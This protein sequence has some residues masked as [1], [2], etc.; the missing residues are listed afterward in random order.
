[1]IY[2]C[3]LKGRPTRLRGF[4]EQVYDIYRYLPPSTQVKGR[5][6]GG[7]SVLR[8][9]HSCAFQGW[10]SQFRRSHDCKQH[11]WRMYLVCFFSHRQCVVGCF[12]FIIIY[13]LQ[14]NYFRVFSLHKKKCRQ[15][16]AVAWPCAGG[17]GFS[18]HA[19]AWIIRADGSILHVFL[20]HDT[21]C[22]GYIRYI[23][24]IYIYM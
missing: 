17:S 3:D 13:S 6:R 9:R 19:V 24:S 20:H 16:A 5:G 8:P 22:V 4:K 1:M 7:N 21:R 10:R 12:D 23:I 15:P 14:C 18:D 11:K 2:L